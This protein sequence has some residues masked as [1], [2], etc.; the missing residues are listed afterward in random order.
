[1]HQQRLGTTS[2]ER[3]LYSLHAKNDYIDIS[4][5]KTTVSLHS[6]FWKCSLRCWM[7]LLQRS[8]MRIKQQVSALK[9]KPPLLTST[10]ESSRFT[11]KAFEESADG[12]AFIFWRCFKL[13]CIYRPIQVTGPHKGDNQA[14][15]SSYL[16]L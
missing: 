2:V 1:M 10:I 5:R 6:T 3:I 4:K 13:V 14:N 9:N 15:Q 7:L 12:S 16:F 11:V 8:A